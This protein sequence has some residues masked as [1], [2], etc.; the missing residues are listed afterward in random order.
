MSSTDVSFSSIFVFLFPILSFATIQQFN[1]CSTTFYTCGQAI[2]YMS[3]PFWGN[4]RPS[5]CGLEGFELTCREDNITTLQITNTTFRVIRI[6]QNNNKLT[7]ALDDL[8]EGDQPN[9]CLLRPNESIDLTTFQYTFFSYVPD[10]SIFQGL[11][12]S[13]LE[14]LVSSIPNRS[15]FNCSGDEEG[16]ANF[17]GNRSIAVGDACERV[18][19]VPVLRTAF[20]DI[21][22]SETMPLQELLWMGFQMEY[23]VDGGGICSRCQ[24]SGG[25]CWSNLNWENDLLR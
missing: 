5:Y 20:E 2:T 11:Y 25:S 4:G 14:D 24:R 22:R 21:N 9:A 1:E 18:I 23:R 13:C 3:Y 16:R 10:G 8:W 12:F 6:D 7:L 19:G 17:I 15:R